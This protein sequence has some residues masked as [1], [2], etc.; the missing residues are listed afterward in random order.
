MIHSARM[1]TVWTRIVL[2][3]RVAFAVAMAACGTE[4]RNE[5]ASTPPVD[6]LDSEGSNVIVCNGEPSIDRRELYVLSAMNQKLQFYPDFA[7]YLGMTSVSNCADARSF[8]R[9]YRKFSEANPGFDLHQ[10]LGAL[11]LIS[12]LPAGPRTP[13]TRDESKILNGGLYPDASMIPDGG[14]G[15]PNVPVAQLE[16][17]IS[18]N[19]S[20]FGDCTGTFIAKNWIAT[21]AHCLA[22]V[23]N[24]GKPLD[25]GFDLDA[26]MS[27]PDARH[28]GARELFGYARWRISWPNASGKL[29]DP[30]SFPRPIT[31]VTSGFPEDVLQ[32]PDPRYFGGTSSAFDVALLYLGKAE[33]D[34]LLPARPD[35]GAA[36]RISLTT[37]DSTKPT[38]VGGYA[39]SQK[40]LAVGQV[41]QVFVINHDL[42][43]VPS[44]ADP[45]I[46]QGDSGGP[47]FQFIRIGP[48]DA[49]SFVPV[50]MGVT[51]NFQTSRDGEPPCSIAGD[52][53]EWKRLSWERTPI[54]TDEDEVS[55]IEKTMTFW[56]GGS[57]TLAGVSL[58]NFHCKRLQS[59][60]TVAP[61]FLQC[62]GDPCGGPNDA[63]CENPSEACSRSGSEIANKSD[64]ASRCTVCGLPG[65][66]HCI[67]GECLARFDLESRDA[68]SDGDAGSD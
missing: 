52:V 8:A 43:A 26:A 15:Y 46:C 54:D 47:L 58:P 12:G 22:V 35:Q 11:P 62:W 2:V 1:D 20:G 10:P 50:L 24:E 59:L 49:P 13:P 6:S 67:F 51:S 16:S 33:F 57:T 19:T 5:P 18:V 3:A 40:N 9:A 28:K 29:T 48:V 55:F 34:P 21:A 7:A 30:D 36:M 23:K 32:Y 41:P 4:S 37:P 65:D 68:A 53:Q 31:V 42:H 44:N 17:L 25:A 38:Y 45:Q 39:P 63:L 60:D 14:V 27:N 66:C 56:N 64:Q 61:D